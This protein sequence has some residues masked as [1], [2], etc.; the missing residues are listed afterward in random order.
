[1]SESEPGRYQARAGELCLTS[2]SVVR[3]RHS[4][5]ERER[6]TYAWFTVQTFD[7]NTVT[8]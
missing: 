3:G 2:E 8:I 5:E 4:H 1:M 6:E 7:G